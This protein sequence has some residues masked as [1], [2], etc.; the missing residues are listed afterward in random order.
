LCEVCGESRELEC[1]KKK[2]KKKKI[3]KYRDRVVCSNQ[4][5]RQRRKEEYRERK[6][7]KKT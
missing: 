7:E 1:E 3:F 5:K 2:K 4:G 6:N